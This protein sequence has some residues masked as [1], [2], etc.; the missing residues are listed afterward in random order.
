MR[1][2]K[3]LYEKG[4][5][6]VSDR[7]AEIAAFRV[8][9][10]RRM[11]APHASGV[12]V[13]KTVHFAAAGAYAGSVA[14]VAEDDSGFPDLADLSYIFPEMAILFSLGRAAAAD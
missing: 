2:V 13:F 11:L 5:F 3:A 4:L 8:T 10:T 7:H 6:E 9:G 1:G 14:Q 12:W